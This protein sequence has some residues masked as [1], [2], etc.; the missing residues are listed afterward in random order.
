M[1]AHCWPEHGYLKDH[2]CLRSTGIASPSLK[3]RKFQSQHSHE[4]DGSLTLL[5]YRDPQKRL[6]T[7]PPHFCCINR[8]AE[9]SRLPLLHLQPSAWSTQYQ[10]CIT[11]LCHFFIPIV[12]VMQGQV[13]TSSLKPCWSSQW[14][15]FTLCVTQNIQWTSTNEVLPTCC[16]TLAIIR[17]VRESQT[18]IKEVPYWITGEIHPSLPTLSPVALLRS[19]L[20]LWT[21][22]HLRSFEIL[23]GRP[24]WRTNLFF[25]SEL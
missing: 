15:T 12:P 2:K 6:A 16:P 14:P 13:S 4:D 18:D 24:F 11:Y 8:C 25:F 22:T 19:H 5:P 1:N 9:V 23:Y 10:H 17:K 20:T 21:E 3:P 7:L